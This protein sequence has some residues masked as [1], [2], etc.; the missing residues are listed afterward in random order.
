MKESEKTD[1][2]TW[3]ER[4]KGQS[5]RK[6]VRWRKWGGGGGRRTERES[7]RVEEKNI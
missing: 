3:T 6:V 4:E 2:E 5:Q 1:G 7:E